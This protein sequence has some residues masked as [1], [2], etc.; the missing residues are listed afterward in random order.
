MPQSSHQPSAPP[1]PPDHTDSDLPLPLCLDHANLLPT[2]HLEVKLFEGQ[3]N[4]RREVT[5]TLR[6]GRRQGS[7][8]RVNKGRRVLSSVKMLPPREEIRAVRVSPPALTYANTAF[9]R[10]LAVFVLVFESTAASAPKR[11]QDFFF[12]RSFFRL[13]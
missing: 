5:Q 12:K 11:K 6:S 13:C 3:K 2:F 1:N 7:A 4:R 10:F 9:T 8:L